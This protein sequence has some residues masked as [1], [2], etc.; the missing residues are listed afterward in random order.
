MPK[1]VLDKLNY[2]TLTP[3]SLCL[4]LANQSVRYPSEIAKNIQIKTRNFLVLVDFAVLDIQIV[5]SGYL[6]IL[7]FYETS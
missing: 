4:Q 3:T 2:S 1:M 6:A 7:A 5:Y